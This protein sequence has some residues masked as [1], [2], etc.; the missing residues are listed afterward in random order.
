[1]SNPITSALIGTYAEE[2]LDIPV[3]NLIN[4]QP[5]TQIGD[6]LAGPRNRQQ[7]MIYRDTRP[8]AADELAYQASLGMEVIARHRAGRYFFL[9]PEFTPGGSGLANRL[10]GLPLEGGLPGP[11]QINTPGMQARAH[12]RNRGPRV[13]RPA[14]TVYFTATPYV[15]YDW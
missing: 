8:I 1:M 7:L 4:V 11:R 14:Q 12:N 5:P 2:E 9:S 10:P 13:L 6:G 15:G 3:S